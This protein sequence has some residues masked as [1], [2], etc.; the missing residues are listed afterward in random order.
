MN[1]QAGEIPCFVKSMAVVEASEEDANE[2][3]YDELQRV[4]PRLV[5]EL[6]GQGLSRGSICEPLPNPR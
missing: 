4:F 2:I 3:A 1:S 6:E 5:V